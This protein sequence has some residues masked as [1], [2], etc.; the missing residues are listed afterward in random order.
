[1]RSKLFVAALAAM[2]L[3]GCQKDDALTAAE[4]RYVKLSV[5]LLN[6]RAVGTDSA[7]VRLKLDSVY[8]LF[9]T[10]STTFRTESE[11]FSSKPDRAEKVFRAISD[12]LRGH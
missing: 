6:A 12:S 8:R 11:A 10:D 3:G 4:Q 2:L 1:M 9:K 5:A 7:M